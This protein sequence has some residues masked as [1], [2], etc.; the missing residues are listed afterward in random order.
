MLKYLADIYQ[1]S[2]FIKKLFLIV[3]LTAV[4]ILSFS[5]TYMALDVLLQMFGA[6]VLLI[7]SPFIATTVLLIAVTKH[8]EV[9]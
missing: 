8:P 2:N 1:H 3:L 6:L 5:V 4:I 9:K 7:L